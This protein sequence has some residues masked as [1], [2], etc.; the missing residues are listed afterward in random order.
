M[1]PLT[2][3][4]VGA[5]IS[6]FSG[7]PVALDNPLAIGA[8]LGAMSPDLDFVVKL[9]KDDAKYLEHHRGATHTLPYLIGFSVVIATT[10]SILPFHEFSFILILL[11]TFLGALSHTGLDIM[12]SYGAKLFKRKL[13]LSILTLY[14]PVITLVGF[15]LILNR[16][17][18]I[19]DYAG[20]IVL[21]GA[22]LYLRYAMKRVAEKQLIKHFELSHEHVEIHVI[23]ALKAFYKW[24]FVA[25]TDTHDYVGQYNSWCSLVSRC[26]VIRVNNTF[27]INDSIYMS[28]FRTTLIG[29]KFS[30]FSPNLHVKVIPSEVEGQITLRIVDLRYYIKK[31]FLHQATLVIDQE[32]NI[33]SS[34]FHPYSLNKAIPI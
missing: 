20:S 2:H 9:F 17:N 28:F 6:A 21:V 16:A 25:H 32:F 31:D 7:N 22:Y 14:D 10:L 29:E 15:H 30:N 24:D 12:N 27:E 4:L 5:A 23:P 8:M 26:P 1:D 19:I 11:W 3:G 33:I 34:L 13:K 18:T